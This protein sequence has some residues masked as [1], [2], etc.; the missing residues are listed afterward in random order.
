MIH[1][2]FGRCTANIVLPQ[3]FDR[4][5]PNPSFQTNPKR[6]RGTN[7]S[8]TLSFQ[9]NLKRERGTVANSTA[10][11][12]PKRE[13][14]IA[15][16][17]S[18]KRKRVV[19]PDEP[20]PSSTQPRDHLGKYTGDPNATY[21]A[22]AYRL[23][24]PQFLSGSMRARFNPRDGQLYVCGLDG[25]QTAATRDGCFQ[26]VRVTGKPFNLPC[27]FQVAPGKI[28]IQFTDPLDPT[29]TIK[30]SN[31][32]IEQ[33]NY[34]YSKDY[35]S[36]HYRPS[37]PDKI[38]HDPVT[39]ESIDLSIDKKTVTLSIPELAPVMQMNIKAT[40]QATDKT[41]IQLDIFNTI[42]RLE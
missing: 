11:G 38:G 32:K 8:T 14:G 37:A 7:P 19:L 9:T 1:T 5:D 39:I 41:P 27:D 13:R 23:P 22:A 24:I 15:N 12:N 21:Q 36:D 25:W 18:T 26:R 16:N 2:S 10:N 40:L 28:T 31:W 3:K 34:R 17:T 35:G 33:W 29:S 42:H 20:P 6:E 4:S 30:L